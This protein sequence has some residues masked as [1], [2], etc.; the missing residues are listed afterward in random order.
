MP[1]P[2]RLCRLSGQ[3]GVRSSDQ[4]F[5]MGDPLILALI[6]HVRGD[7]PRL[8]GGSIVRKF[9]GIEHDRNSPDQAPRSRKRQALGNPDA[10]FRRLVEPALPL[11]AGPGLDPKQAGPPVRQ[12]TR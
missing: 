3:N 11:A 8:E 5:Q 1:V 7:L 9:G 2:Y 10:V 12:Q 6:T 4:L